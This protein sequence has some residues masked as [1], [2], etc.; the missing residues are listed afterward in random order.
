M[1]RS[2]SKWSLGILRLLENIENLLETKGDSWRLYLLNRLDKFLPPEIE[3]V[4]KADIGNYNAKDETA[5]SDS[6]CV[7]DKTVPITHRFHVTQGFNRLPNSERKCLGPLDQEGWLFVT[8]S[9]IDFEGRST[10]PSVS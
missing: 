7:P 9:T 2:Q 4:K 8:H 3:A 5:I 10:D 6:A 1:T